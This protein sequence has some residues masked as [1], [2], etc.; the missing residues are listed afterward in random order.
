MS[1]FAY[2]TKIFF[3]FHFFWRQGLTMLP[4]L[5]FNSQKLPASAAQV[6][7]LKACGARPGS[8]SISEI[9]RDNQTKQTRWS[10]LAQINKILSSITNGNK[11]KIKQT[12]HQN[13]HLRARLQIPQCYTSFF[14]TFFY[15]CLAYLF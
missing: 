8:V 15:S 1:V 14:L 11:T 5:F 2:F 7:R 10:L 9:K 6:L 12:K 4:W 13:Y 3:S